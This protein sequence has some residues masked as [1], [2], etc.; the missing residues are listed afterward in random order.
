MNR[1]SC[2]VSAV[3][4]IL[5]ACQPRAGEESPDRPANRPGERIGTDTGGPPVRKATL[6]SMAAEIRTLANAQGCSTPAQCESAPFGA[7]PCGG[8]WRYV[9]YCSLTTDTLRLFR[10]LDQHR[11]LERR[12]NAEQGMLSDCALVVE[13][14]VAVVGNVCRAANRERGTGNRN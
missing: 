6:D 8:P 14:E 9:V 7:K 3:A 10:A 4:L 11:N 12:F 13:P 5:L 1:A 2:L